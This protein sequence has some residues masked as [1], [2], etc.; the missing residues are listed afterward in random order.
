MVTDASL[1]IVTGMSPISNAE[2]QRNF[3]ERQRAFRDGADNMIGTLARS[4]MALARNAID[5]GRRSGEDDA[6]GRSLFGAE[7][8]PANS[9]LPSPLASAHEPSGPTPPQ[10][11]K[12]GQIG[13][14]PSCRNSTG[15]GGTVS[16]DQG[17]LG[18]GAPD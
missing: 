14:W 16:F 15:P 10:G 2:R 1:V 6:S 12:P 9:G 4:L 8:K 13:V 18:R 17:A 5:P 3:R 11:R 7:I